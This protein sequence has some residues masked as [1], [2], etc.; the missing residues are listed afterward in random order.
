[1]DAAIRFALGLH[2]ESE[3]FGEVVADAGDDPA[4]HLLLGPDQ[5]V[6]DRLGH[7]GAPGQLVHRGLR[8][9]PLGEELAREQEDVLTAQVGRHPAVR[10]R[11]DLPCQ[12]CCRRLRRA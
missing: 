2:G 9:P 5:V 8:V 11:R 1:M 6:D 3:A 12:R 7:P 10:M 4:Q